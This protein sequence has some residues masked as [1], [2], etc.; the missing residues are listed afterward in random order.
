V[1]PILAVIPR[2]ASG[3]APSGTP[4]VAGAY[5]FFLLVII[6]YVGIMGLRLVRNQR[7][8]QGMKAELDERASAEELNATTG[9]SNDKQE[10]VA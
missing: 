8:I 2:A 7:E 9:A 5:I 1:S 4:Y 6:I 3:P 10:Q